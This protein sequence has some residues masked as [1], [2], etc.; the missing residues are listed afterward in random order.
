M[1]INLVAFNFLSISDHPFSVKEIQRYSHLTCIRVVPK[2]GGRSCGIQS[3]GDGVPR[4]HVIINGSDIVYGS[5]RW[6]VARD[7]YSVVQIGKVWTLTKEK[8]WITAL[9]LV[10]ISV[11]AFCYPY[12]WNTLFISYQR[13][14]KQYILSQWMIE[15]LEDLNSSLKRQT[16]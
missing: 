16:N 15:T 8:M 9:G 5:P 2:V 3:G 4:C 14:T 12:L 11:H 1:I 10:A 6:R 7:A 13:Q